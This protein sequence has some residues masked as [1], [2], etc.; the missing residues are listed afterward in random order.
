MT[1]DF[2]RGPNRGY[3]RVNACRASG[4]D[5][6]CRACL[7]CPRSGLDVIIAISYFVAFRPSPPIIPGRVIT[8]TLLEIGSKWTSSG[9]DALVPSVGDSQIC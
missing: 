9:F 2:N 7:S 3:P 1:N 8:G 6:F 4:L 5:Y